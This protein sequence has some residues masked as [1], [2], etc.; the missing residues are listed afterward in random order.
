MFG[1][2]GKG[3]RRRGGRQDVKTGGAMCSLTLWEDSLNGAQCTHLAAL[4]AVESRSAPHYIV[5][6]GVRQEEEPPPAFCCLETDVR[7]GKFYPLMRIH[8]SPLTCAPQKYQPTLT[9][10]G[11]ESQK[12]V[13]NVGRSLK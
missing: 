10:L 1:G 11:L 4:R 13:I 7:E 8:C 5:A 12:L 6:Q 3:D 2:E 9:K